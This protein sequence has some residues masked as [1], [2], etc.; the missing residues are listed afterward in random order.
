MSP[1]RYRVHW[2]IQISAVCGDTVIRRVEI[3]LSLGRSH[4]QIIQQWE[5]TIR[6]LDFECRRNCTGQEL[7]FF[8]SFRAGQKLEWDGLKIRNS[9]KAQGLLKRDYRPGWEM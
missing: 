6:T 1:H 7:N 2:R 8:N 9:D 4:R 5:Q 3:E